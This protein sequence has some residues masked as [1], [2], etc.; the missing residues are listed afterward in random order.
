M[1]ETIE[2]FRGALKIEAQALSHALERFQGQTPQASALIRAVDLIRIRLDQGGK[3]VVT[4]LGKSGK[5]AQKIA[6]T[7]ASTGNLSVFLHPTEGLHGDLGIVTSADVLLALSH[8]GNTEEIL[9]I[10]LAIK[11]LGVPVVGLGGNSNSQLAGLSDAWIDAHVE[12]E[13]CPHNLAPTASTTLALALGD[14]LAV[15]LMKLRGFDSKAFAMNHPGGS[16][17]R[18]LQLKVQDVMQPL[19]VT[20][21]VGPDAPMELVIQEAG[22]RNFGAVLVTEA[23]TLVG[24][25]TDGDLRR[26]LSHREKFFTLR[27]SDIMTRSPVIAT[28]EMLAFDALEKMENRPSQIKELPVVDSSRRVQGLVRLHDLIRIF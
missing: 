1:N 8:T 24:I 10:S 13:A 22:R 5:I 18:R 15:T 27:A 19:E 28:P 9:K 23:E 12:Q 11:T 16:L 4:G 2:T 7:L 17:G 14:A 20:P 21:M 26:A 3:V 6:A 25:I